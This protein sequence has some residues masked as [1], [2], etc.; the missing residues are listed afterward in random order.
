MNYTRPRKYNKISRYSKYRQIID[1]GVNIYTETFNK[2]NVLHSDDDIFHVVLKEEENRLDIISYKYYNTAEY[3]WV[4][5]LANEMVDPFVVNVGSILRI[6]KFT[7]LYQ[8]E[9]ALYKRV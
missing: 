2:T 5:A 9:G 1:S 8:W 4:I 3:S 7:S 6:P